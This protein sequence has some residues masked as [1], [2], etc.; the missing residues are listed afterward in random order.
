M[1][2]WPGWCA[3]AWSTGGSATPGGR[4]V[5]VA[6][7]G[8]E[9]EMPFDTLLLAVSQ[10]AVFGFFD[11]GAAGTDP[12]RL[13]GVR[14]GDPGDLAAGGLR[15]RRRGRARPGLH[16]PGRR[17]RQ[18]GG[19]GDHRRGPAAGGAPPAPRG[20]AGAA[21]PAGAPGVAGAGAPHPPR[22]AG[23]IRR[24]DPHLHRRRRPGPRRPA[25]WTATASAASAWGSAPT[26]RSSP[27]PSEPL[28]IGLPALR[29]EGGRMVAGAIAPFRVEQRLQVAVLT[30]FCNE[31]GNCA[32]FCPTA[33]APYRD[34][35]RLYLDRADFEAQQDNAFMILGA[36][37]IETRAGGETL[38]V[39]VEGT[40][41]CAT[42][43]RPG[44]PRP[45]HLGGAGSQRGARGD[46]R[47][48]AAGSLRR[49]LRPAGEPGARRCPP[50]R[51]RP[52]P[53]PWG[54]S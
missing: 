50:S 34:K 53:G 15:R 54:R 7:E 22:P 44:A 8:S 51:R 36:T 38:R 40:V 33:G 39:E 20:S 41:L 32:T 1:G 45:G 3:P 19:G 46:R 48:G 27:T 29:V 21:A 26:W 13:P 23:R 12:W 30:D 24:N 52:P 42:P 16:R 49:G 43:A 47:R 5:P 4:K 10:H 25:A 37:A 6:V 18:A 35:P 9:H 2:T 31:C 11:A 17:R 28:S 14:P